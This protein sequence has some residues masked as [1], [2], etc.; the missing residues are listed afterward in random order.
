MCI[1]DS[2]SFLTKSLNVLSLSILTL[3]GLLNVHAQ[4]IIPCRCT[5]G[6]FDGRMGYVNQ[7]DEIVAPLEHSGTL[8]PFN[9]YGRVTNRQ[10]RWGLIDSTG[11]IAVPIEFSNVGA[12]VNGNIARVSNENLYERS[13]NHWAIY[14]LS[15]Q[16]TIT[17]YDYQEINI[18]PDRNLFVYAK[19]VDDYRV[20]GI[21]NRDGKELYQA[22]K[23]EYLYSNRLGSS[24]IFVHEV[25]RQQTFIDSTGKVL[26]PSIPRGKCTN[27]YKGRAFIC[28]SNGCYSIDI[29]GK[30]TAMDI[31]GIWEYS[32]DGS[33]LG[34]YTIIEKDGQ[35]G[36]AKYTGEIVIAPSY[37]EIYYGKL[38]G[39]F[40]GK[41]D[42]QS[43]LIDS[44]GREVSEKY[45]R[46]SYAENGYYS[47]KRVDKEGLIDRT[48]KVLVDI[49]YDDTWYALE[50]G[51][52]GVKLNDKWGI[53]D[54]ENNILLPIEHHRIEVRDNYVRYRKIQYGGPPKYA[55]VYKTTSG[56]V[57]LRKLDKHNAQP[58]VIKK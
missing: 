16:E 53:I 33:P 45:D 43:V 21:L 34:K 24:G 35:K 39:F 48:G 18:Y 25:N 29:N 49:I 38:D 36:V 14:S 47:V 3:T 44:T 31:D 7:Q 23:D 5:L 57:A 1:R 15:K 10:S 50:A 32:I 12:F 13:P 22:G 52:C 17:G 40:I 20:N 41:K 42:E 30:L 6:Q 56:K 51:A 55:Y 37:E 11:A 2:N 27:F 9:G 26:F 46:I 8:A 4:E 58:C 54:F 19:I 28:N